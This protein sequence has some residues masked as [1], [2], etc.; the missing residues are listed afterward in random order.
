[1]QAGSILLTDVTLA[2]EIAAL[3]PGDGAAGR[4]ARTLLKHDQL[5][6]V[7]VTM[8]AGAELQEH[9]APGPIAIHALQGRFRV[10]AAGTTLTLDAGQ[11]AALAPHTPHG[12]TADEDGAFLLTIA[13]SASAPESDLLT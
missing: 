1:M 2:E 13:W 7:L 6:I 12:V 4:R 10:H 9:T 11:L 5:R 3:N 8:R